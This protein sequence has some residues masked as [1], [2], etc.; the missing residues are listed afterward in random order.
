MNLSAQI[1]EM[2]AQRQEQ[3]QHL[4]GVIEKWAI[5]KNALRTLE[6]KQQEHLNS[7]PE[8][9]SN[10]IRRLRDIPF[11]R[12]IGEIDREL[13]ELENLKQRLSRKTLNIGVVGRMRQG[14]S[15]L[16]QSL[17]GLTDAEIPTSSEGVC[18]RVLSKIF[19]ESNPEMVR[20]EVEF[21]SYSS[22]QDILQLYFEKLDLKGVYPIV[23]D[24]LDIGK[25]PPALPPHKSEDTNARF[26]S[27]RLR[28]EYYLKY[29]RYKSLLSSFSKTIQIPKNQIKQYTT[30]IQG[31]DNN[32]NSEYLAVK[33]LRI[34]CQ[35]SD[36]EEL[37]KI[38][39]VDLP[40]LGDDSILDVELLIKT[41]KQDIDFI[42]FVRRPDPIGDD[43]QEADRNMYQV[44]H[45]ALGDFPIKKCSFMVFNKNSKQEQES[46]ASCNRFQKTMESQGI[47]VSHSV[48]AD[49]TDAAEVKNQILIPVIENLA[50]NIHNV[51]RQYLHFHNQRLEN[52]SEEISQELKQ[53]HNA[54]EGFSKQGGKDI[55]D[56]FEDELWKPLAGN[57]FQKRDQLNENRNT[58]D[59]E[60]EK[61]VNEVLEECRKED[62]VPSE[63]NIREF[64]DAY[65]DSY[66][67]AYYLC[68]SEVKE[69][70]M[71]KF[72]IL[73]EALEESERNLQLTVVKI[74][75]Q[76]AE[77]NKLTPQ[78]GLE[79]FD[80]IEK[81]I[82]EGTTTNK[83]RQAFKEI[84][85]ST[86]TYEDT[87]IRWIQEHLNELNPDKHLDPM[88]KDQILATDIE[89]T[90]EQV[91]E[92]KTTLTNE[93]VKKIET[94]IYNPTDEE[95]EELSG[96]G[97]SILGWLGLP[98]PKE[99]NQKILYLAIKRIPSLM[100]L[101]MGQENSQ[102]GIIKKQIIPD[103]SSIETSIRQE[104]VSLR[105]Q[106]VNN[107]E[108]T[109][110]KQLSF[111]NQEAHSKF[112]KF[113]TAAFKGEKGQTAW[114]IFYQD[115]NNQALLWPGAKQKE[116]N[117][118]VEQEWQRLVDS[119]IIIVN[120]KEG[121]QLQ[122]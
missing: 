60:F 57:I 91:N 86:D 23:P 100:Q 72:Q 122:R 24:D 28:K 53:A 4:N 111:P 55:N 43:W 12:L 87:I 29:K 115:E 67:I 33:E 3:A 96:L 49:C 94:K 2:I 51:Y 69:K 45:H 25:F 61:K 41:L 10:F 18:T 30:Q 95:L 119:A 109:L 54:L 66:K 21:H 82:P 68:I 79:F 16:L 1:E 93:E 48:I 22:L 37:G 26:L 73:A 34:H 85:K 84:K 98:F 36:E 17:T 112:D 20:N 113:A 78:Q 71:K 99:L 110:R 75:S 7:N 106:V 65:G 118:L 46:L 103:N 35:F 31:N 59:I 19:H 8:A 64:R 89:V 114:R 9:H 76:Y 40:G 97:A 47:E 50:Q 80:E 13:V 38:G 107:C 5:L 44:A 108:H 101:L 74:L 58:S 121:L 90:P 70:L 83:L 117:K 42:I 32:T 27:L 15:R 14:K 105:N 120:N 6:G 39:V 77:L 52:L 88:S 104:I 56:W 102:L 62:I 116:E 92:L 81:Q 11:S 63:E